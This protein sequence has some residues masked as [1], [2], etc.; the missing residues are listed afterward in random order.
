[1][2]VRLLVVACA[3][4]GMCAVRAELVDGWR[5]KFYEDLEAQG[6]IRLIPKGYLDK[7]YALALRHI[8]G[9]KIF[10]A[11]RLVE[12][13]VSGVAC[14]TVSAEVKGDG[15]AEVGVAME[16]FDKDGHTLG[17]RQG[18]GVKVSGAWKTRTWTF[19]SPSAAKTAYLHVLSLDSGLVQFAHVTVV[20]APCQEA[21]ALPF[22][23]IALPFA[24]NKDW[25]G[26]RYLFTSFAESPQPM[27][28]ALKGARNKLNAPYIEID[29]PDDLEIRDAFTEHV[30]VWG[31]ETPVSETTHVR[32]GVKYRRLRYENVRVFKILDPTGYAWERKL[33]LVAAPKSYAD[34]KGKTYRFYWRLGDR[35]RAGTEAALD[36][37][38]VDL[39][40]GLRM[41][42][43]FEGVCWQSDDRLYSDDAVFLAAARAWELSGLTT[44]IRYRPEFGRGQELIALLK[45]R[46]VRWRFMF[47]FPDLW[48]R[49][50]LAPDTP[51]YKALNAPLATFSDGRASKKL[52]PSYFNEDP[53]FA[54][55]FRDRIVRARLD[56]F[57]P[58]DGDLIGFDFE[59]WSSGLYCMCDRCRTAFAKRQGLSEVPTVQE[60][61]KMA[62]EWAQF[63]CDQTE[64]SVAKICTVVREYNPKLRLAD[65]DYILPYGTKDEKVFYTGCAK[66]SRQNEK[67]FDQ[68]FCSYYHV[69]DR[70]AFL[71]ISNNTEYLKKPYLP[72]GAVGG[73]GGYLRAG[74]VRTPNQIRMLALAAAVHG[75]P[76]IGFYSGLHY[77]GEHLLALMKA[78]DEI[79]SVETF[80]WGRCTGALN[81][82]SES[83]EFVSKSCSVD[84]YE[85]IALFNYDK[86]RP[87]KVRIVSRERQI[88]TAKDPVTRESLAAEI[89]LKDG[90]A[91]TVPAEDVRFVVFK[92]AAR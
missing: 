46:P 79:A 6:E 76:G 47:T 59:P 52:C 13:N 83:P 78:R 74:E 65:Y 39:P 54:A 17:L 56:R 12:S 34:W 48:G 21:D 57:R 82:S 73:Y 10:G 22:E 15:A 9:A 14:W 64:Q 86:G 4:F 27:A 28:F 87:A 49:R 5:E 1:M 60:I 69:L 8:A 31:R 25:N 70:K 37:R 50:F 53:E 62:D 19:L 33:T 35:L 67:W 71:A 44:F 7:E 68:H 3:A 89:D 29:L 91:I 85:A 2:R 90:L 43:R 45:T 80:P 41:P 11:E 40:K 58:E 36:I 77:D 38:F 30:E 23:G 16:F 66:N 61:G 42:T 20:A 26:G 92:V 84:G 72:L 51:E 75:C 18:D 88:C 55:Y 24:W 81:A 63:R 32:D